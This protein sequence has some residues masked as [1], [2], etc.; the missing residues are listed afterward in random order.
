MQI[1]HFVLFHFL[2]FIYDTLYFVFPQIEFLNIISLF[3]I[4]LWT[5]EVLLFFQLTSIFHVVQC[6]I[7]LPKAFIWHACCII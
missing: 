7:L 5:L 2:K 3:N 1:V 4:V 6:L